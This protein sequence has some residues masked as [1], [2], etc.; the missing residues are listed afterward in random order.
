MKLVWII[1]HS[2]ESLSLK[3]QQVWSD[4]VSEH[5]KVFLLKCRG[6]TEK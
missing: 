4:Y 6:G 5:S 2:A 3:Y 1:L